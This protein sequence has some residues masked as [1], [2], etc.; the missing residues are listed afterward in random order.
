MTN[1]T[2]PQKMLA[3]LR[4]ALV[5]MCVSVGESLHAACEALEHGDVRAASAVVDGDIDIN[6]LENTIDAQ[7]LALLVRTQP[8]ATDLRFVVGALR[9]VSDLERIGDEAAGIAER[10]IIMQT[11]PALRDTRLWRDVGQLMQVAQRLY[12]DAVRAFMENNKTL[13]LEVSH[14][15]D[16]AT[17]MEVHI[18]QNLM[19]NMR[20]NVDPHVAMHIILITRSCNRIW[21]RATNIAQH[22]YF[23][24]E[25]VS[26]KHRPVR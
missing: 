16:N 17:Q 24:A 5:T 12:H 21:S 22:A 6:S 10:T 18:V 7:A 9:M 14:G 11:L 4:E 23:I 25:G 13:A 20:K 2:H 26:L 8:V 1:N 19:E 3:D 15:D